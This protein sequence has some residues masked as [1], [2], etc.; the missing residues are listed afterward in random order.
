MTRAR[1]QINLD[2]DQLYQPGDFLICEYRII[3]AANEEISV[4]ESS[5]LWSTEGKGEEDIGVHF[6]E[7]KKSMPLQ[8]YLSPQRLSTVLPASPL[9][10]DGTILKVNWY[11][12]VRLFFANGEKITESR[13][14]QLGPG[15]N[16]DPHSESD[17]G[18]TRDADRRES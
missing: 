14:F 9:S 6:F 10:Y 18:A 4:I 15:C 2:K 12:R 1:I 17:S 5:V 13:M 8:A 16:F 3:P 11:V 7:R